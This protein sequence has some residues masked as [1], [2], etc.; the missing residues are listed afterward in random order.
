MAKGLRSKTKRENRSLQRKDRVTPALAKQQ[1]G[2]CNKL[3][4]EIKSRQGSSLLGLGK[5]LG[6]STA[7]VVNNQIEEE[8]TTAINEESEARG[9]LASTRKDFGAKKKAFKASK[10]LFKAGAKKQRGSKPRNNPGKKMSWFTL[11]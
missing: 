7:K 8:E 3:T 9:E 1:E 5:L 11:K 10:P 2:L 4:E 6:G